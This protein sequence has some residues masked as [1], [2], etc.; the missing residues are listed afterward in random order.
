MFV[1][2]GR[3]TTIEP[4]SERPYTALVRALSSTVPFVGPETRE[5][6][7]GRPFK[8]RLGA[9]ESVF[10]PSPAVV[11]ALAEAAGES[12][13]YGD[14]ESFELRADLAQANGV[15][16]ENVLVGEGIDA[17]LGYAVRLFVEPGVRVATSLGAYPTFNFHVH[18]YG[19][20]LV[21]VPYRDDR[22][23][24]D[25]LAEAARRDPAVRVI[26]LANPDN[27]MGSWWPADAV[28]RFAAALPERC[29]LCLDEA[30][31][32]FAPAGTSPALD[33]DDPR[34]LR[35]R[36]FSKAYGMAGL[37]VGYLI[38]DA[39]VVASFHK[40]RNHFGVNRLAQVAAR[41]AL[42]DRDHLVDVVDRVAR[43]RERIGA[44]AAAHG[45][46]A[47][48]S[49]TNFVAVDAGGDGAFAR[50]LL[51]ALVDRDLFLRMP[52]VAPL[53]RCLRIGAGTD[54]DLDLLAA[55]LPEA[56]AEARAAA[57]P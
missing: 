57:R 10:G 5:R 13:R 29:T 36:T 41:A 43:A 54:A 53:D 55:A 31:H 7:R 47:L 15:A 22:E 26:Y 12:W 24:L 18:G 49:A 28:A 50:R 27:P 39:A 46:T 14:P 40:I 34:V 32:E 35:F 17:L 2:P 30:Y 21:T 38:A 42:A 48:P 52:A 45:L 1:D 3:I 33:V 11:A 44:I 23:D 56:L 37:R 51:A 4:M 20:E 16:P 6:A 19:G 25:G 8:A 9:N